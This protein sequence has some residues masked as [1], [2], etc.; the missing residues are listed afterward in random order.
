MANFSFAFH[1][2]LFLVFGSSHGMLY[3]YSMLTN[4][5]PPACAGAV[6]TY[7]GSTR[8]A[9]RLVRNGQ[10]TL[11]QAWNSGIVQIYYNNAWGNICDDGYFGSN[12]ADVICHQLSYTGASSYTYTANSFRCVYAD[13]KYFH[14]VHVYFI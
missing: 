6:Y 7:I 1:L 13:C 14:R 9:L 12:E 3:H 2:S 8:G 11:S 4:S 5:V 10:T